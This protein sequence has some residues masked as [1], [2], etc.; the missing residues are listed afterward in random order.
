MI[1]LAWIAASLQKVQVKYLE[2]FNL[3]DIYEGDKIG[4]EK[5][6]FA[7]NFRFINTE[8]TLT[9][10]EVEAAMKTI[11]EKLVKDFNAEIRHWFGLIFIVWKICMP[12][13][14]IC[15]LLCKHF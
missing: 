8:R 7:I 5:K 13:W 11:T 12:Q 3:F 14:K 2:D 4:S 6:S 9:D 15:N 10:A 1:A